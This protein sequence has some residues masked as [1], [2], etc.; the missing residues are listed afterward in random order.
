MSQ[1]NLKIVL[2]VARTLWGGVGGEGIDHGGCK[3]GWGFL[4]KKPSLK[5]LDFVLSA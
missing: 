1:E 4:D 2:V 5:S 3:I